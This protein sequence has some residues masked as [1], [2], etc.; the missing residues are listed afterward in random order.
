[1]EESTSA[2]CYLVVFVEEL[3]S[4]FLFVGYIIII[5]LQRVL[6]LLEKSVS[7]MIDAAVTSAAE[8]IVVG[9]CI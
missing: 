9:R 3:E 4:P 5:K 8:N 6:K 1:M 7:W 2:V